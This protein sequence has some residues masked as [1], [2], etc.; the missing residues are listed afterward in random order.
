MIT[1]SLAANSPIG[2]YGA[3]I[4]SMLL[5]LSA[6]VALLYVALRIAPRMFRR[7]HRLV[8]CERLEVVERLELGPRR[9][10]LL[11]RVD[12][13]HV[14]IATT[15]S[16]IHGIERMDGT[17]GRTRSLRETPQRTSL[18]LLGEAS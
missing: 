10:L 9:S 3:S 14:L 6:M 13:S 16:G 4:L 17:T 12:G 1:A 7:K 11:V 18:D 2:D 15:E 5:V 8:S